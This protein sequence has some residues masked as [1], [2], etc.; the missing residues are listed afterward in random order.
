MKPKTKKDVSKNNSMTTRTSTVARAVT[1]LPFPTRAV[2]LFPSPKPL[3]VSRPN[4]YIEWHILSTR[5]QDPLSCVSAITADYLQTRAVRRRDSSGFPPWAGVEGADIASNGGVP[6]I[7]HMI[8]I[9]GFR[10]GI[11]TVCLR[12]VVFGFLDMHCISEH[13]ASDLDRAGDLGVFCAVLTTPPPQGLA[14]STQ[15]SCRNPT[16]PF[17]G[18]ISNGPPGK[19]ALRTTTAWTN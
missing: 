18:R 4:L 17:F 8:G 10:E 11:L 5:V 16:C 6:R 2:N 1:S 3:H 7:A 19:R 12:S 14:L 15:T 9:V 13:G